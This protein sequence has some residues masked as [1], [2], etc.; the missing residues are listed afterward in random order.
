MRFSIFTTLH[1]SVPG[2]TP[3]KILDNFR[4]QAV[5]AEELDSGPSDRCHASH[6]WI[7]DPLDGTTNYAHGLPIFCASLALEID[8]RVEVGL[9]EEPLALLRPA[10][11]ADDPAALD[12]GDLPNDRSN[13]SGRR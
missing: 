6:R 8:G 1:D 5:L 10:R 12:P 13:S 3:D 11:D 9:F 4:E 2:I 7:F